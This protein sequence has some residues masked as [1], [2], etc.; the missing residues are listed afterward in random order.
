[1]I[2]KR[3]IKRNFS[4]CAVHYDKY[5]TVQNLCANTLISNIR[6]NNFTRILELG[7]GTGNYTKLLG[8][9][10]PKSKIL[11]VDISDQML[12]IAK[13]KIH[14]DNIGF[15]LA[16]AE[17][18][19]FEEKFGL[20][21]S[22]ATFQWFEDLE[23]ALLKY[24]DLLDKDGFL[25]FSLFGPRTFFELNESLKELPT[26]ATTI[27][28][29]NFIEKKRLEE[30]LQGLFSEVEVAEI[31]YKERYD[32][33]PQLLEKIRYTGVRGSG[34]KGIFWTTKTVNALEKIYK[35]KFQE[36]VAT[37]QVFFCKG[38]K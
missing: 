6:T 26:K 18:I 17:G 15:I 35:K 21:S 12:K 13:E 38:V 29:Q 23:K 31:T 3:T 33:L 10:F 5:S 1:M 37:Y 27:N 30:I 36:I 25:F 4:K 14:R 16:D 9:R 8:E 20:I 28:S 19:I 22:N 24:K 32:S 7:C 11:A 2:D 34:G